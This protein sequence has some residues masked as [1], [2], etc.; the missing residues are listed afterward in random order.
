MDAERQCAWFD[1]VNARE[2][3]TSECVHGSNDRAVGGRTYHNGGCIL[4][5]CAFGRGEIVPV[6]LQYL[7]AGLKSTR[8]DVHFLWL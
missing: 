5:R 2:H 3:G 7:D 4:L 8:W 1:C 6:K